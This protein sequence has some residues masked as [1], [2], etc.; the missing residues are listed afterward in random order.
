MIPIFIESNAIPG[1][2]RLGANGQAY[3]RRPI[4]EDQIRSLN[5]MNIGELRRRISVRQEE[6]TDSLKSETLI[7]IYRTLIKKGEALL[8]AEIGDD[9]ATTISERIA[10]ILGPDRR[11]YFSEDPNKDER[12]KDYLGDV[13]MNLLE[14]ISLPET[15]A[16][17]YAEVSFGQFIKG[18]ASNA[19]KKY[20]NE[21]KKFALGDSLDD[22]N[23]PVRRNSSLY[24]M[25]QP[26]GELLYETVHDRADFIKEALTIIPEPRRTAWVLRVSE[27]WQIESPDPS[28]TTIAKYFNVT[29]RTVRNWLAESAEEMAQWRMP[30]Q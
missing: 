2:T 26:L 22:L 11:K 18:L 23:S 16:G 13:V 21:N 3:Q 29:G 17:D 19:R 12:F 14:K 6:D 24:S 8:L 25:D 5:E 9:L 20:F 27:G 4:V 15:D 30:R 28:V 10:R 1:L 7:F